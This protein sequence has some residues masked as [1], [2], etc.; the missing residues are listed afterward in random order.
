MSADLE[1]GVICE[2]CSRKAEYAHCDYHHKEIES[3]SF[4]E[5]KEEGVEETTDDFE[6]KV[7]EL[8]DKI[9]VL[10]DKEH[11]CDNCQALIE[12]KK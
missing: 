9:E 6:E 11:T 12:L 4:D 1:I 2:M 10:Q 8:E 3:N 5:G 7:D